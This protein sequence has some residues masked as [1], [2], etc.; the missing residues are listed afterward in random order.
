MNQQRVEAIKFLQEKGLSKKEICSELSISY[1]MLKYYTNEE[2]RNKTI[3][4]IIEYIKNNPPLRG[5]DYK[6][7]QR[8]YQNKRY[9]EDPEF[10]RKVIERNS[11]KKV[12]A[13]KV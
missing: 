8:E 11:R 3:K 7:Y 6:K 13:F 12:N 4:R 9:K 1:T 5:E 2:Y 10:R